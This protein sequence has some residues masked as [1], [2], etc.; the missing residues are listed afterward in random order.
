MSRLGD[1]KP[2]IWAEWARHDGM[3]PRMPPSGVRM[4]ASLRRAGGS[5]ALVRIAGFGRPVA[6]RL[7]LALVVGAAT[8]G[9]AIG[10]MATSAWLIARAAERPP[11]LYLMVAVTGVRAF[12]I[13]RGVLRYLE[14]L[15]AHD[16]AFRVLG[17]LRV[18]A[19]DRL[20]RLAP[21]GLRAFRSGDLLARVVG[22]VDSLADVWLRVLLPYGSAALA[23]ACAV[24]LLALLVPAAGLAV[25]S[26]VVVASLAAPLV[27]ILASRRA[28]RSIGPARGELAAA[29]LDTLDG[30]PELVAAGATSR[31]LAAVAAIDTRLARAESG[32]AFGSGLAL[33]VAGL[34]GGAGAWLALAAG[35]M[36]VGDGSLGG[37]GLAV[38]ALTPLAVN[39]LV[40][41]LAPAAVHLPGLVSAASR[42]D[43]ILR[44]PAPVIEP[45]L[46]VALPTGPYGLRIRDLRLHYPDAGVMDGG[47]A[48][49]DASVSASGD[50]SVSAA[51]D[52]GE[53]A[54][55][56]ILGGLDLDIDPGSR[57]LVTGP[58]GS[59]KSSLAAALLRFLE[60]VS[61]TIELVGSDGTVDLACLAGP[62][63]RRVIGLCEQEPH[64]FD[65]T[66]GENVRLARPDAAADEIRAAL[67]AAQ[68]WSW[69]ATLPDGIDTAVGEH[70]VGLSG[71]QR[72]RLSV[73]R[74]LLADVPVVVLDEPTEHVD[75]AMASALVTDLLSAMA[76]RTVIVMTHRPELMCSVTWSR[77]VRLDKGGRGAADDTGEDEHAGSGPGV[78]GVPPVAGPNV[79]GLPPVGDAV[80]AGWPIGTR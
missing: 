50:A 68:L 77:S 14:R 43:A 67:A 78:A 73:A 76:G 32:S 19:Y 22:D 59:G 45:A 57:T 30:A 74:A 8:A 29:T 34:A 46:P 21:A 18:A 47:A 13:A 16:A 72:Q 71:G 35:I 4:T 28:D 20:E 15:A 69:I 66:I 1:A 54:S 31:V 60:P 5:A 9:A 26:T 38:V 39:E 23:I 52:V 55:A 75:E 24:V 64:V 2:R 53:S 48:A 56:D 51:G 11:V 33:F 40:S 58:S 79:A 27:G 70:G 25:A 17:E 63:V 80:Q 10:L 61:G 62:D 3:A 41:G 36:S 49:G 42:V 12:G 7:A 65:S 6:A 44:R 37:V